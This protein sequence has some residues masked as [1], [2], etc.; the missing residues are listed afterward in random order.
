MFKDWTRLYTTDC[1]VFDIPHIGLVYPIMKNGSSSLRKYAKANKCSVFKNNEIRDLSVIEVF[2]REP[3]ERFVSGVCTFL[4]H[5]QIQDTQSALRDIANLKTYDRHFVPQIF[6]L[7]HLYKFFK[8][9]VVI[10]SVKEL[11]SLID[12]R[13]RPAPV[14]TNELKKQILSVDH[15]RYV[16]ADQHLLSTYMNQKVSLE[17]IVKDFRY[18]LS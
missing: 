10:R 4:G 3:V 18:V 11:Y 6:W 17:K 9:E 7:F 12:R 8:K 15:T 5:K 2:C 13:D 16:T 14:L 1:E